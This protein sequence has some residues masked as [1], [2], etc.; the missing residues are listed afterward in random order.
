VIRSLVQEP[1][2]AR[3]ATGPRYFESKGGYYCT[4]NGERHCLAKGPEDDPDVKEA[5]ER[6]YHELSLASR[7]ATDGDRNPCKAVL[8]AFLAECRAHKKPKTT[9]MWEKVFIAFN[10]VLGSVRVRDLKP[11]QVSKWLLDMETPR[12]HPRTGQMIR[13]GQGTRR[14][15]LSALQAAFNWAASQGIISKNPIATLA[16]PSPRSRG[17]DQLLSEE[18]HQRIVAIV[19]PHV[20]DYLTALHDTGAR[21]G[22]VAA[23]EARHL[24]EGIGAWV[25]SEHK[26]ERKGKKRV[27]YLTPQLVETTKRLAGMYPEG[28][29][30]RNSK[31]R[32]WTDSALNHWFDRFREKLRLG[33]VSPYS[34]RHLF[35]TQ[36]LLKGGSMAVLAE[37]LGDTIGMIEHHYG[38]LR[39]HGQQLR[40]FLIDFRGGQAAEQ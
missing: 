29:L 33:A 2:M 25:L 12:R 30:F 9:R 36:F 1:I 26:T 40:Q 18:D 13:W 5:A 23:V 19:P 7:V 8:D 16:V 35:A 11:H 10:P 37:L 31:G 20:R 27:I 3:K 38:H 15:A 22:E 24:N 28:P 6:K 4:I 39:E 17:G 14:I 34:Y 32:P 21:P